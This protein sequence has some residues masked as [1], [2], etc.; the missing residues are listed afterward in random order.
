M[1][2][3]VLEQGKEL[4]TKIDD[5]TSELNYLRNKEVNPA[6]SDILYYGGEYIPEKVGEQ[7]RELCIKTLVNQR[8]RF[9]REFKN[10]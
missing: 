5:I 7:I 1:N 8:R 2:K 10:L 9:Q 3:D 6:P 4:L